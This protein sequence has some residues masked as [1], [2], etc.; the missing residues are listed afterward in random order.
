LT[1]SRRD[2]GLDPAG[3]SRGA[4]CPRICLITGESYRGVKARKLANQKKDS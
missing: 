1:F 4:K 2:G 3:R